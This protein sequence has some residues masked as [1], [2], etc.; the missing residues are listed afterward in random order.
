MQTPDEQA[1][2]KRSAELA[3]AVQF[4]TNT[5][6]MASA[7][8]SPTPPEQARAAVRIALVGVVRLILDF[9]PNEPSLPL[10]FNQLLYDLF[11]LEY[12][13][14]ASFFEPKKVSNNPGI[15]LSDGL[16]RA[17]AAAAMSRLV[18]G[19]KMSLDEAAHD[20]ARKLSKMGGRHSSGKSIGASQITRWR[21]T[22]MAGLA[23]EDRGVAR[24]KLT[25]ELVAGTEPLKAVGFLMD[26]LPYLSPANFPKILPS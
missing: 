10:P 22:M 4:F 23:S 14:V 6:K 3:T 17:I 12:G 20:I 11:D 7:N 18:E 8:Y 26:Q 9:F 19:T 15:S 1:R 21:E 24:Y 5:I 2:A 25:L 13:R 16:F